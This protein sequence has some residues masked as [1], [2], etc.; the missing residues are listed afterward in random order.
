MRVRRRHR[1]AILRPR[2]RESARRRGICA[3]GLVGCL[4]VVTFA[5]PTAQASGHLALQSTSLNFGSVAVGQSKV[6]NFSLKNTGNRALILSGHALLGSGFSTAEVSVRSAHL[7]EVWVGAENDPMWTL[8]RVWQ[9]PRNSIPRRTS[10]CC[11]CSSCRRL[12]KRPISC[13]DSH[14]S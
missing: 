4:L 5:I 13:W 7:D 11:P 3:L 6:I 9:L 1:E 8:T 14:S 12:A 2:L 10:L